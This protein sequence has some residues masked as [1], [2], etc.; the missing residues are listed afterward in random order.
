[1]FGPYDEEFDKNHNGVM[2]DDEKVAEAAYIRYMSEKDAE[3]DEAD[4]DNGEIY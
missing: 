4:E 1:M 2:E 3:Y